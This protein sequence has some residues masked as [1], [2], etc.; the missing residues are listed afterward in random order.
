MTTAANAGPSAWDAIWPDLIKGLPAAFVA[1]VIGSVAALIAWRQYRVARA[2]LN[3]DLFEQRY[4]LYR[5]IWELLSAQGTPVSQLETNFGNSIPKAFF[6]FGSEVGDFMFECLNR[7]HQ[8]R[9]AR[10]KL[11][12]TEPGDPARGAIEREVVVLL[13]F[14]EIELKR[15]RSRFAKYMDFKEWQ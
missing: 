12:Q 5:L 3:L 1:L 2:K 4:E 13:D 14:W 7:L 15:L 8:L 11:G 10:R 9:V 6:L